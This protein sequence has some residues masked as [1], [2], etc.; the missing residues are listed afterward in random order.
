MEIA[1]EQVEENAKAMQRPDQVH[2]LAGRVRPHPY[3]K[4]AGYQ[5]L[6][7][8]EEQRPAENNERRE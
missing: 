5:P 6:S 8:E 1:D 2:A 4:Y 7:L 3:T